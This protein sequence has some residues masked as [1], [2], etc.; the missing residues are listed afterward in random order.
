MVLFQFE[1]ASTNDEIEARKAHKREGE[2]ENHQGGDEVNEK[3][4][5]KNKKKKKKRTTTTK[6]TV[7]EEEEEAARLRDE[8]CTA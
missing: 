4:K 8:G 6:P 5:K 2:N 3:E 1:R 7:G